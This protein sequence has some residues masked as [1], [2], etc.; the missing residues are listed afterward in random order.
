[1]SDIW[2][3]VRRFGRNLR[4]RDFVIGD[5]HGAYDLVLMAMQRAGFDKTRDR[6]FSV[7][8]LVDRGPGSYR[9]RRF[10][11]QPYVHACRGNHEDM[12][13]QL[14]ANGE[15]SKE[16]LDWMV[17]KNGLGWWLEVDNQERAAILNEIRKL[18]LAMELETERGKVGFIHADVPDGMSW[19]DLLLALERGDEKV[20][21]TVLWGRE[22]IRHNNE[23]GVAGVGRLFVGHTPQWKGA[24]RFGNVYAVDTGAVF[25][26]LGAEEYARLSMFNVLTMT[27]AITQARECRLI[28]VLDEGGEGL[29]PFGNYVRSRFPG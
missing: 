22:R 4:G 13:L 15:P 7:G 12:L 17:R 29:P 1:M 6:L 3:V 9:C 18:P 16:V 23:N 19:Q 21:Q 27:M 26:E 2:E 10:L 28:D 11:Q 25:A 8:D 24:R 20:T 5:V 14:Y